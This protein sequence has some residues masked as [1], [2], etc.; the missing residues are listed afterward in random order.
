MPRRTRNEDQ[1]LKAYVLGDSKTGKSSILNQLAHPGSLPNENMGDGNISNDVIKVRREIKGSRITITFWG[2]IFNERVLSF[3]SG[4]LKGSNII[5]LVFDLSRQ[6]SFESLTGWVRQVK[7]TC[8]NEAWIMLV[9]NKKDLADQKPYRVVDQKSIDAFV[10]EH[11]VS[12]YLEVSALT[13]EGIPQIMHTI[14]EA[15]SEAFIDENSLFSIQSKGSCEL[16][17]S[18]NIVPK[19]H[20][21]GKTKKNC[22][23]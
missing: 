6:N 14:T 3:V 19:N 13:G 15:L 1:F 18:T 11:N 2:D 20:G 21:D 22:C 17:R 7:E 16:R 9:G 23:Y 10:K 8:P 5:L 12:K 4:Q